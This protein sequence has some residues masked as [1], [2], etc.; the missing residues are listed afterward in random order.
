[1]TASL[2]PSLR[3]VNTMDVCVIRTRHNDLS[4]IH[5]RLGGVCPGE[6]MPRKGT[7]K[8]H[9]PPSF[10]SQ[11]KKKKKTYWADLLGTF[12]NSHYYFFQV[13]KENQDDE[14]F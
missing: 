5:P 9:Q 14:I 7:E 12:P 1:M 13:L 3:A 6:E 4:Q 11:K 10:S 8:I 2:L